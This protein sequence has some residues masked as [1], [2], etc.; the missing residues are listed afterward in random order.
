L[1]EDIMKAR[2]LIL[3]ASMAPVPLLMLL[4]V[5]LTHAGAEEEEDESAVE[6]E[7]VAETDLAETWHTLRMAE[8]HLTRATEDVLASMKPRFETGVQGLRTTALHELA[9]AGEQLA[10]ADWRAR[11]DGFAA[12]LAFAGEH[13]QQLGQRELRNEPVEVY[14][15][16]KYAF[17]YRLGLLTE[18]FYSEDGT[19]AGVLDE[20]GTWHFAPPDDHGMIGR[21]VE[22]MRERQ[23]PA[24]LAVPLITPVLPAEPWAAEVHEVELAEA[25]EFDAPEDESQVALLEA[26]L[27]RQLHRLASL[28]DRLAIQIRESPD[29]LYYSF[30]G[31]EALRADDNADWL[32][33]VREGAAWLQLFDAYHTHASQVRLGHGEIHTAT[34]AREP[35]T[36]LS[37]GRMAFAYRTVDGERIGYAVNSPADAAGFRW[38]EGLDR[39]HLEQLEAVFAEGGRAAPG[40]IELPVDVTGRIRA[41]TA[42][43]N[44]GLGAMLAAGG[45]VMVPLG[46]CALLALLIAMERF[47][48][49][50]RAGAGRK[51]L[52]AEVL[53]A[54][55]AGDFAAAEAQC[56]RV[57]GVVGRVLLASLQRRRQ[58]QHAMEDTIQE[59]LLHEAPKLERFLPGIAV[60]GAVAPLF[61]LLGTV[62]GIIQTFDT[63]TTFGMVQP[64]AMAGGISEALVTTASGLVVAIPILL[65]HSLLAG[66]ADRIVSDAEKHAAT[67]ML[68]LRPEG[69]D[70]R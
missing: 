34:G 66:K 33:R 68:A 37:A 54:C 38:V 60:L 50:Q 41:E 57:Q 9:A 69:G 22:T 47:L 17:I 65:L 8:R 61:G 7:S 16:H 24:L 70:E 1:I 30:P 26:A 29:S 62:T 49:L 15:L 42:I 21:I 45:P 25:I 6:A 67:L 56:R 35:V 14:E 18:G 32:T 52:A 36:L 40:Y 55:A 43:R 3:R 13:L 27:S 10:G 63:I 64:G 59:Q 23:A 4:L 12:F 2:N 19:A 39:Q 48:F 20:T 53:A 46:L 51:R 31:T 58:G 11:L 28:A 5:G 44:G